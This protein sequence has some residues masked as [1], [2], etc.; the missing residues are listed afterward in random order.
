MKRLRN[1]PFVKWLPTWTRIE[2]TGN[3]NITGEVGIFKS[4]SISRVEPFT[5][6][7]LTM[8]LDSSSYM[9]V[10]SCDDTSTCR[11]IVNILQSCNGYSMQDVGDVDV[12]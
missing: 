7:Y 11:K 9:G 8:D 3:T 12:D 6:C 1:S 5:I 2:G 10:L 4:A